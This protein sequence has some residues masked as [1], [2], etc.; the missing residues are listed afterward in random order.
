M[1]FDYRS[2]ILKISFN[3]EKNYFN[4]LKDFKYI[5]KYLLNNGL[6][7]PDI[8]CNGIVYANN[9][10][11]IKYLNNDTCKIPI[12]LIFNESGNVLKEIVKSHRGRQAIGHSIKFVP[13]ITVFDI[14]QKILRRLEILY[15][16]A[17]NDNLLLS[18]CKKKN[19]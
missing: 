4:S 8:S 15:M 9:N 18:K 16:L 5:S 14:R 1:L 3:N 12:S 11:H 2:Y 10:N 13:N 19:V 6:H 7:Y 17:L